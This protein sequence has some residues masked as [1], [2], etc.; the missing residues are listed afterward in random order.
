MSRRLRRSR[1]SSGRWRGWERGLF[2][3]HR[4]AS[5]RESNVAFALGDARWGIEGGGGK[6]EVSGI[7]IHGAYSGGLRSPAYCEAEG[8]LPGRGWYCV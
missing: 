5:R 6:S 4:F 7:A 2:I 3:H 1:S 8:S